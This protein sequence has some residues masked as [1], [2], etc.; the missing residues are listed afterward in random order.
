MEKTN[1]SITGMT[2]VASN[3]ATVKPSEGTAMGKDEFLKLL[4]AQLQAQDPLNPMDSTEFTAQLAQF[5]SLEQLQNVNNNL[6]DMSTSQAV[7]SNSQAVSYIGKT[8]TAVGDTVTVQKDVDNRM[9]IELAANSD[10]VYVTISDQMGNF[11]RDVEVG[12]LL[13]GSHEISWDGRD[14]MGNTVQEGVY[15]FE[16]NAV[17]SE[18]N[19][20]GSKKFVSGTV[21]GVAFENGIAYLVSDEMKIAM[22]DVISVL[23]ESS[24]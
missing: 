12:A 18:G 15:R 8:I 20:V 21:S 2:Q 16:V 24:L 9:Q 17:D 19:A 5:S 23:Q 7:L 6:E 14:Y 13:A 22:G 1:M 3:A 11:I 4:V 10:K